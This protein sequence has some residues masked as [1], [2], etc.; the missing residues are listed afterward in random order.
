MLLFVIASHHH[1]IVFRG[2]GVQAPRSVL[3]LEL[4]YPKAMYYPTYDYLGPDPEECEEV[5]GAVIGTLI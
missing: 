2:K 5:C 3:F 4:L 1:L